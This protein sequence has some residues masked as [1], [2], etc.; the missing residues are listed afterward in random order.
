MPWSIPEEH[1]RQAVA[2]AYL[3]YALPNDAA[4]TAIDHAGKSSA[5]AWQRMIKRG[6]KPGVHDWYIL[7]RGITVW[8][9]QKAPQTAISDTQVIWRDDVTRNGATS[10]F[11]VTLEELHVLLLRAGIPAKPPRPLDLAK[12]DAPAQIRGTKRK[13]S[14]PRAPKP[15]IRQIARIEKMRQ[16]VMF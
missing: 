10:G 14:K 6:V 7:W 4:V 13:S 11:F 8:C 3:D 5:Q 15:G 12:M 16:R 9:D 1:R 2:H